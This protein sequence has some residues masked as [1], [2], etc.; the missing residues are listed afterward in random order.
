MNRNDNC[1]APKLTVL[2]LGNILSGDDGIGVLLIQKLIERQ[3]EFPLVEFIDGGVGGLR[4][5]NLLEEIPAVL[6]VDSAD[7][8]L[9]ASESRLIIPAQLAED[10]GEKGF[11]LHD[12]S[13]AQ[14]LAMAER[15]FSRPA[16]VIFAIQPKSVEQS[17]K[18]SDE[19]ND[20][21]GRL[22]DQIIKLLNNW[23]KNCN[24]FREVLLET[25]I[26]KKDKLL[27]R[28]LNEDF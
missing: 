1:P 8:K 14:T 3:S 4:L 5:L 9:Q 15:F 2:G 28:C 26:E 22:E 10:Q 11:S 18:L 27:L 24:K 16:T 19:L 13:F 25:D 23:R 12:I 6:I 20:A 7:M 21:F 17:D